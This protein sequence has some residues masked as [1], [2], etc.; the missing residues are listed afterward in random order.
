MKHAI[1]YFVFVLILAGS[2]AAV[3]QAQQAG[4]I[5]QPMQTADYHYITGFRSARFGMDK[6]EVRAA[7]MQDFQVDE[8]AISEMVNLDQATTVL[9]VNLPNLSPGPGP[10]SVFYIFGATTG[11]LMYINVV[12][13]TSESPSVQERDRIAVAGLQLAHYFENMKWK[14]EG[15]VSGVSLNPGEVLAF[16]GVDPDDAGVQVIISGVPMTDAEGHEVPVSGPAI[17]QIS[18][19]ARYGAA[20]VI[21]VES[22]AF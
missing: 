12:W 13:A 16:A 17:L 3:A 21:T 22:G 15:A 2:F 11:R 5:A 7:I 19:T 6:T 4:G 14:P 8:A 10:A 9:A 1:R 18:Y 20:D